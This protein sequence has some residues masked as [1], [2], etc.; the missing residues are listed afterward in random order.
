MYCENKILKRSF[1]QITII[2]SYI[3]VCRCLYIQMLYCLSVKVFFVFNETVLVKV[4]LEPSCTSFNLF[5]IFSQNILML[6]KLSNCHSVSKPKRNYLP[7]KYLNQ[8]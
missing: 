8:A 1:Y 6:T 2:Q 3:L 5:F 7:D 4:L